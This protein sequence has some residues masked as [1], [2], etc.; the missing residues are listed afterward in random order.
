MKNRKKKTLSKPSFPV[1]GWV[2]LGV[3]LVAI[4]AVVLLKTAEPTA[5]SLPA[6]VSV[7]EASQL[8]DQNAFILDVREPSEW[9]QFH[10][11]G[12]NLIPLGQLPNRLSEVPKDRQVVVVCRTGHRSAQGRDILKQAGFTNVTSMA[13]GVTAWQA[14]GLA[15][16]TGQ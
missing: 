2:I 6:E 11:P 16:A 10:I 5:A 9:T 1:W 15:I 14:Q 13:G 12:A 3:A 7:A 8:R 4:I